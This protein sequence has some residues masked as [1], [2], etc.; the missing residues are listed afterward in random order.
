MQQAVYSLIS[1]E[2]RAAFHLNIGRK[3]FPCLPPNVM[4]D[5]LLL[6]ADQITRGIHLVD[7]PEEKM[8]YAELYL[9]AG[10][11]AA[12]SSAFSSSAAFLSLGIG[13]LN[14]RSWETNYRLTLKLHDTA[15]EIEYYNGNFHQVDTMAN[16]VFKHGRKFEDCLKAHFTRIYSLGSRGEMHAC[17]EEGFKVLELLGE[18][19]PRNPTKL[20]ATIAFL[21]CRHLLHGK[22]DSD[23]LSLPIMQENQKLMALRIIVVIA[24]F[25]NS[26]RKESAPLLSV[27][28]ITLTM[29]YGMNDM[30]KNL[31]ALQLPSVFMGGLLAA[32]V[33]HRLRRFCIVVAGSW[34]VCETFCWCAFL[35]RSHFALKACREDL[36]QADRFG[37]LALQIF[38]KYDSKD[39]Q[40]RVGGNV[41]GGV[42]PMRHPYRESL[43][44]LLAA[45]RSGLILGDIHVSA[46]TK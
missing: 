1:D 35:T 46:S 41:Y 37:N 11:K 4:D 6:V 17:V 23:I 43:K 12:M 25:A 40:A 10:Q 42:Y 21:R 19:F 45:H 29:H 13:Q 7:D 9:R 34:Y 2:D 16:E 3:L 30:C 8:E 20:N 15:A 31:L 28:I 24:F 26:V 18:K 27:R 33:A 5:H 36:K 22:R 44:P 32:L 39:W 38:N 14:E